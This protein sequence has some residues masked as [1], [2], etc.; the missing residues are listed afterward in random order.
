[1][2]LL[3]SIFVVDSHTVGHP[4][5]VV[6]GGL[7]KIERGGGWVNIKNDNSKTRGE[8]VVK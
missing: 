8:A 2:K 6:L 1:M 5:R 7:P 4:T 3:N